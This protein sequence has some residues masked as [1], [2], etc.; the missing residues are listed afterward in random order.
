MPNLAGG[1]F[2]KVMANGILLKTK[3]IILL[4]AMHFENTD[5]LA[6]SSGK[7]IYLRSAGVV[8]RLLLRHWRQAK[9]ESVQ[10]LKENPFPLQ[11]V[12][13]FKL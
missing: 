10:P 8:E 6:K 5:L 12:Y 9:S 3:A 7:A 1:I 2:P 4:N 13:L 11:S